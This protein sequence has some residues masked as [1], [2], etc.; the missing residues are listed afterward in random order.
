M[1]IHRRTVDK[2]SYT[3]TQASMQTGA[4]GL[5]GRVS[6]VYKEIS[7]YKIPR[8]RIT[9]ISQPTNAHIISHK[10]L[11]NHFKTL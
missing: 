11:L 4:T 8:S 1:V 6:V 9:S 5:V 10:T 3:L 2:Y 7:V